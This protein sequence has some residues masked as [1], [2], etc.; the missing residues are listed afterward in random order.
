MVLIHSNVHIFP[1]PGRF[2]AMQLTDYQS[3]YGD[4]GA[5]V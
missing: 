1:F 5:S 4:M 2:I 3:Y